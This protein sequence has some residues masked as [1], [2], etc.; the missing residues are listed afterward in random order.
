MKAL[1][2]PII[3]HSRTIFSD[4]FWN[5]ATT[6][7]RVQQKLDNFNIIEVSRLQKQN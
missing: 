5:P 2:F 4:V 6:V 3:R 1:D 7:N